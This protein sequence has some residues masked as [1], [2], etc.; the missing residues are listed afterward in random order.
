MLDGS[1]RWHNPVNMI[2]PA[3]CSS[4]VAFLSN[5]FDHLLY[6]LAAVAWRAKKAVVAE[7]PAHKQGHSLVMKTEQRRR[8]MKMGPTDAVVA[9]SP[10]KHP[11]D[12]TVPSSVPASQFLRR[13]SFYSEKPSRSFS[14]YA[15]LEER[16]TQ[17]VLSP[18]SRKFDGTYVAGSWL[19]SPRRIAPKALFQSLLSPSP[20]E[21]AGSDLPRRLHLKSPVRTVV[22]SASLN[23]KSPVKTVGSSASSATVAS[24]VRSTVSSLS[25]LGLDSPSRNTRSHTSAAKQGTQSEIAVSQ[26]P[27]TSASSSSLGHRYSRM[28]S[29]PRVTVTTPDVK[30][31]PRHFAD[32]SQS[33][34]AKSSQSFPRSCETANQMPLNS[35]EAAGTYPKMLSSGTV[36]AMK[37]ATDQDSYLGDKGSGETPESSKSSSKKKRCSFRRSLPFLSTFVTSRSA[38][39]A[40]QSVNEADNISGSDCCDTLISVVEKS[41]PCVAQK[42]TG[43]SHKRKK[44]GKDVISKLSPRKRPCRQLH[45]DFC[46]PTDEQDLSTVAADG[47]DSKRSE[48]S[49]VLTTL[50]GCDSEPHVEAHDDA[51]VG[52]AGNLNSD[53]LRHLGSSGVESESSS[54]DA[55]LMIARKYQLG[56]KRSSGFQSLGHISETECCPSPVFPTISNEPAAG[57]SCQNDRHTAGES[58]SA[59]PVFGKRRTQSYTGESPCLS[60]SG[61]G[62]KRTPVPGCA[63]SFSPDVSQCSI[64]HLMTSPLLDGSETVKKTSGKRSSTRRC[65]DHQMSQSGIRPSVSRNSSSKL[66]DEDI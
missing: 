35:P 51:V 47:G 17:K 61:S 50:F 64:A 11:Q 24:P 15:K 54:N 37:N 22:S 55:D 42:S 44:S 5:C 48:E 12:L 21:K 59:S 52:H 18:P 4:D 6:V 43:M 63:E 26:Q 14:K 20:S 23:F 3:M 45:L 28:M 2:E 16:M 40:R 62:R 27:D 46:S 60:L 30:Q 53:I 8:M 41:D 10:L 39:P 57:P 31:K 1:A 29:Q 13:S 56:R 38:Q 19:T 65:L 32:G 9:E 58:V 34:V 36:T 25:Q 7:T 33:P 49:A 66:T